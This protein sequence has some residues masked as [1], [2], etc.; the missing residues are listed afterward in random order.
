M[1]RYLSNNLDRKDS[2]GIVF[3]KFIEMVFFYKFMYIIL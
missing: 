1:F 2:G 3:R